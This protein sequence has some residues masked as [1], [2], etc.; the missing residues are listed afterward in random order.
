MKVFLSGNVKKISDNFEKDGW[1]KNNEEYIKK[2]I[3]FDVDIINPNSM[4]L[5][6]YDCN[7]R[8]YVDITA[9][10][11]SDIVILN[12]VDKC[13][14]GVGAELLL[15]KQYKIP[16]FT[17]S[18]L[19]SHYHKFIEDK[20]WFHSFIYE[21]SDR[22]F[23]NVEQLCEYINYLYERNILV[24][25]RISNP[26]DITDKIVSFDGGYDEGYIAKE[27][28]WG[29]K[30]AAGVL[31]ISSLYS[32]AEIGKVRVLDA[33]C[34]HGKNSI[35]LSNLGFRVEGFDASFYAIQ[36]ARR[37]NRNVDWRVCDIRKFNSESQYDV[38]LMTGSLHCL[39]SKKEI[40]EVI[41]KM[42]SYTL[43]GGYNVLSAFNDE[44]QDMSGHPDSFH[45]TLLSHNDY[46]KMY[47]G[48]DI[49]EES[50]NIQE[51][52]HPNNNI[53]HKHSITR[54]LARKNTK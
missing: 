42:K 15:A 9:L 5:P 45:P 26:G 54:I 14:I 7:R 3:N 44:F 30:P 17:I 41:N 27:T 43:I 8:F 29:E 19:N 28:F 13:G 22:I 49:I 18:P 11:G 47:D 46:L 25:N 35:Y 6:N 24:K 51:D 12:A 36:E 32:K 52:I 53:I 31:K 4:I 50:T 48:W 1:R 16:I 21:L 23:E 37:L 20:E 33:G 34:G 39:H 38:I 10:L 40:S 2:L